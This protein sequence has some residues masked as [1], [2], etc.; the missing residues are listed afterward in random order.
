VAATQT[1]TALIPSPN[2]SWGSNSNTSASVE[3]VSPAQIYLDLLNLPER[4]REAATEL[5]ND[6]LLWSPRD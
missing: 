6:G 5:R 4:A 2:N 3:R 1:P